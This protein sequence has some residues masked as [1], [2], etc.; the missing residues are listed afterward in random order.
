VAVERETRDLGETE[1]DRGITG[2]VSPAL[3][4]FAQR[5]VVDIGVGDAGTLRASATAYLARSNVLTSTKVP[6]RAVPMAVRAAAT[7]TA[8]GIGAPRTC[9]DARDSR[10]LIEGERT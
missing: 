9:G 2:D 3:E 8:S 10:A 6:L 7:M 1:L 5:E 4:R